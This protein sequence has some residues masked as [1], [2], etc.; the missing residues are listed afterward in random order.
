MSFI[1]N[2][3]KWNTGRYNPQSADP[4]N[5][6]QGQTFY[7]DGTSRAEGLWQYNGTDWIPVGQ[8][9]GSLEIYHQDNFEVTVAADL[10][11]GNNATFLGGGSIAGTIADETASPIA[12]RRSVKYT[13][14]VG[15]L[16]DYVA[17]QNVTLDD[18][19]QG[20]LSGATIYTTYTGDDDDINF[21]VYDVTNSNVLVS[22]PVKSSTIPTKIEGFFETQTSTANISYGF[23][24]AV[25]N[26]TA[27][28]VF[29]DIELKTNPLTPTEIF[30]SKGWT[31]YTPST[32]GFGTPSGVTFE[33][34]RKGETIFVRGRLTTGTVTGDLIQIGLPNGLTVG[35]NFN[36]RTP[37][38]TLFRDTTI[39]RNYYI[40]ASKGD[41]FVRV[42]VV[43]SSGTTNPFNPVSGSSQFNNSQLVA[44]QFNC[45][46]NEWSDTN[47][48][49]AV[50]GTVDN[51]KDENTFVGWVGNGTNSSSLDD[52]ISS[53]SR[54]GDTYTINLNPGIFTVAPDVAGVV[55]RSN[56]NRIVRELTS[57]AT[58]ITFR[59][60]NATTGSFDT[61]TD[62]EWAIVIA[63]SGVDFIS[64]S[65]RSIIFPAGLRNPIA[66]L[67]D[68]K[69]TGVDGGTFTSGSYQTRD[70]NTIQ[71]D[72]QIVS[73][74]SNQ[75]T[76]EKGDYLIEAECPARD[77]DQH[78]SRLRNVTDST[79]VLGTSELASSNNVTK[80]KILAQISIDEAK[81]FEI[82]HRAG[83]TIATFGFGRANAFGD[84]E[85]YTQVKITKLA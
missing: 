46:V 15:S 74:S 51:A 43:N 66:I 3:P 49:I 55:P 39:D 22:V 24:V 10:Q 78:Q 63:K 31:S 14:A 35:K 28:L 76:L 26:S 20:N 85:V 36:E 80:S 17:A 32:L 57:T 27:E 16:N 21:I 71:G 52:V 33:Y 81:I 54:S 41:S 72:T 70:L 18:K 68:I 19:Q 69:S 45:P 64:E 29:D 6:V 42:T 23:Q 62:H 73:L 60:F 38:G 79:D 2:N 1:G 56:S 11:S 44:A 4:S 77:V 53:V 50:N 13:Q 9:A 7:S 61:T 65:Q 82:Q 47:Q 48:G 34:S 83:A 40:A 58:T 5:P 30:A 75:F 37:A 25:E 67:K 59:Q 12:L 84:D 8:S